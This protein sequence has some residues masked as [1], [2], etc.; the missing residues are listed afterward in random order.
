MRPAP[1]AGDKPFTDGVAGPDPQDVWAAELALVGN[2]VE[3]DVVIRAHAGII[4]SVE[5]GGVVPPF[6]RRRAG[7]TLP[8]LV[9]DHSHAF[10]RALRGTT[11][12]RDFWGWR[13]QMYEVAARLDPDSYLALARAVYREM[14]LAGIVHVCEFHY[15]HQ[16]TGM[17]DAVIEAAAQAGIGLTFLDACYLR[18]GFGAEPLDAVQQRFCDGDVDGWW[19]RGAAVRAR[20]PDVVF[21]AA[22]HSVRAVDARSMARLAEGWNGPLHL[23]LSE[24]P[25]ENHACLAATGSTPAQLCADAGVLSPRTTVV[26]ATHVT[27]ADIGRL[28]AASCGVCLCPTTERDLADGVGPASALV[29]AGCRLSLG[30]DSHAVVDLFEEA[31]A[32]EMDERL[33]TGRRGVHDPGDLLAAACGGRMLAPGQPADLGSVALDSTRLAG[34]DPDRGAAWVVLAATAADVG[35]VVAGGRPV[36]LDPAEVGAELRAALAAVRA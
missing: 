36:D 2:R 7:L 13:R 19:E 22:I 12:G 24:Q 31:R 29:T 27:D 1:E 5:P 10:H 3:R 9:N 20:H 23:H 16:P 34:F 35:H 28:A 30:S 11:G 6:A 8:G 4:T 33:A 15:L 17:D 26:H 21:G 18:S 25:E 14:L 32:V